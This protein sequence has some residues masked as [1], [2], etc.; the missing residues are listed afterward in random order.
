[1]PIMA[2]LL[3]VLG[4]TGALAPGQAPV[5]PP[6]PALIRVCVRTDEGGEAKEL[7]ARRQ[8]AADLASALAGKKKT[9]VVV[10]DEHAA[11]IVLDVLSRSLM[12]PKVVVGLGPRPGQPSGTAGL[13]R[14]PVLR[15][16]IVFGDEPTEFTNKNKPADSALGWRSA[17][18]N[19]AGQIEKWIADRRAEI[20]RRRGN[21]R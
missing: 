15:V 10:D 20:L 7:A 21:Q 2:R 17:A 5:P 4:L 8:S 12:V 9:V 14:A 19:V 3:L 6:D 18:D 16:R 13:V 1:M 11:D